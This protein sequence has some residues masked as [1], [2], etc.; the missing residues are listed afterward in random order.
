MRILF[1]GSP[2]IAVPAL[3]SIAMM[4]DGGEDFVL[5][6]LLTR[7]DSPKGRSGR[8][9]P[10]ECAAA[11][12]RLFPFPILKPEKLDSAAREQAAA[13]KPDLLVS[14]AYGKIFGPQFL[15]LFP[16][17]G[18]NIHPSLLPKYRGATPIPAAIF[19]RETV[20]GITI[21]SL[22]AEMDS[23]DILVQE[24]V[25]LSG[26]ETTASLSETMAKKAAE[27]LP[28][29]LR[30]IDGGTLRATPQ[31][32][33]AA[34]Y[35]SLIKKEDGLIDWNR[36]AAEIDAQ[37]RAFDPWPLSWTMHGELPLYILKAEVVE[38]GDTPVTSPVGG[39]LP[40][41]ETAASSG[42]TPCGPCSESTLTG[43]RALSGRVLGKDKN[44]GILIQTGGGI[45]A[46]SELQYQARKAL[47]WK[48]FLN[49]ARNF[50]DT[51]LG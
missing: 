13:L 9:E 24:A 6:G 30:G 48:A 16:L 47:E 21:Q 50:M 5:A 42:P 38:A 41:P 39:P 12:R 18:I 17:G 4:N 46:V 2:A 15:A 40:F 22:A 34:T 20:T 14:F 8:P 32:N 49:G 28:A 43:S 1:A 26:K 33:G 44:K 19:N 10:T 3:E 29:A 36:T 25:P 7:A 45:L 27:L 35:C 37:I 11:A 31:D 51:R 23:G